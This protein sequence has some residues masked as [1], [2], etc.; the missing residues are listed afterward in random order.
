MLVSKVY[1]KF[2]KVQVSYHIIITL[3]S[4]KRRAN[5]LLIINVA[6]IIIIITRKRYSVGAR[7]SGRTQL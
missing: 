3:S 6:A 4:N 5:I 7:L 1:Y 2:V